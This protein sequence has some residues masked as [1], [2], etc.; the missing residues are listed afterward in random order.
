MGLHKVWDRNNSGDAEADNLGQALFMVSLF[1]A[2]KHPLVAKVMEAVPGYRKDDHI[3]G[4]TDYAAH[5][6]YQ[7]KWLKFGLKSLALDVQ[8][9]L[10]LLKTDMHVIISYLAALHMKP[11]TGTFINW[12]KKKNNN[13][14]VPKKSTSRQRCL[15]VNSRKFLSLSK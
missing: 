3:V 15:L 4:R 2:H 11:Q 13:Q 10:S 6:V 14:G 8:E 9:M 1:G 5:P 7:T 12:K